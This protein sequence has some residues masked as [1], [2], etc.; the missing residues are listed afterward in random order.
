MTRGRR[1]C[2][3][4]DGHGPSKAAQLRINHGDEFDDVV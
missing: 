3:A 2:R 1:S 4:G